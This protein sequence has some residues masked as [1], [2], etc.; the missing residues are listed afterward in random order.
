MWGPER[1]KMTH[2]EPCENER[3]GTLIFRRSLPSAIRTLENDEL[4]TLLLALLEEWRWRAQ[5][6]ADE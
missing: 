5:G 1:L 3:L 2:S 4:R 6:A